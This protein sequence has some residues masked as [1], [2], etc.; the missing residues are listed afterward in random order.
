MI[1]VMTEY[2]K[3]FRILLF[4]MLIMSA[5]VSL[6]G[7]NTPPAGKDAAASLDVFYNRLSDF[8]YDS[9][10]IEKVDTSLSGL[11][12]TD[13]VFDFDDFY[14]TIGNVGLSHQK[15]S[16]SP[17]TS[18]GFKYG[19][20]CFEKFM[21][22]PGTTLCF[23]SDTPYTSLGYTNSPG[24]D[25]TEETFSVEHNQNLGKLVSAGANFFFINSKGLYVHEHAKVANFSANLKLRS[26]NGRYGFV[27]AYYHS[28]INNEENGGLTDDT[29]FTSNLAS[30]RKLIDVNLTSASNLVKNG[31]W[32][33]CQYLYLTKRDSTTNNTNAKLYHR[34][35]YVRDRRVFADNFP[36]HAFYGDTI[37]A[38]VFDS[39]VVGS[40]LN[41]FALTNFDNNTS[42]KF[43]YELG[44]EVNYHR[45][46]ETCQKAT[47]DGDRDTVRTSVFDFIPYAKLKLDF[48]V[49]SLTPEVRVTV[50]N[51]NMLDYNVFVNAHARVKKFE[52]DAIYETAGVE[53]P[54]FYNRL[55]TSMFKW[56]NDFGKV[57]VNCLR[58][59][60]GYNKFI[61]IG[62]SYKIIGNYV[63]LDQNMRPANAHGVLN[64]FSAFA[65]AKMNVWR[66]V[67]NAKLLYQHTDR[68]DVLRLPAFTG[69]LQIA[70]RQPFFKGKL[71]AELGVDAIYATR[72][73]ADA[74]MPALRAFY[75]QDE[76]LTN[77]FPYF[78]AFLR[79]QVKK[80]RFYVELINFSEGLLG[81][82]YIEVPHYP[83]NDR[84]FKFGIIWY[85]HD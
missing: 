15:L 6:D 48:N 16:F 42:S 75:L 22:T 73:Y 79:M 10:Y 69:K 82:N 53:V 66:F 31:G 44:A 27:L 32:Y 64:Y 81:Y 83:L 85:F 26:A 58:L 68:R 51:H 30:N 3:H 71:R 59:N 80:A 34:L 67:F 78:N 8:P 13:L 40:L 19:P 84:Q 25:K 49:F 43:L 2:F 20:D 45:I 14:N 72:F 35:N 61:S 57:F 63:Y 65:D 17:E 52:F 1:C 7:Q 54:W 24:D 70:F 23:S 5:S 39:I 18:V 29:Q 38:S 55:N 12:A 28:R 77:G 50:G 60:T 56:N 37:M 41:T 36:N 76:T 11:R 62:G 46:N 21:L 9:C 47:N 4:V 74:Y 33:F